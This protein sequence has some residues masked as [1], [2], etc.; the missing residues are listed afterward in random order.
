[1]AETRIATVIDHVLNLARTDPTLAGNKELTILDGMPTTNL[2]GALVLAIGWAGEAEEDTTAATSGQV[3]KY[4]GK[5]VSPTR[6]E[7]LLIPGWLSVW[8]GGDDMKARRDEAT[9]ILHTFGAALRA[10]LA[11][12]SASGQVTYL[13]LADLRLR[14][15]QTPDGAYAAYEFTIRAKALI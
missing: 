5:I 3:W 8:R 10:S 6:E 11:G 14:Q 15:A 9:A 7:E 12:W 13:E 1:M 2:A 4:V